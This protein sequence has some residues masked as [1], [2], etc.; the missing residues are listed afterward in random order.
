MNLNVRFLG[1]GKYLGN[2]GD[3]SQNSTGICTEK[4]LGHYG[5]YLNFWVH[6]VYFVS[7]ASFSIQLYWVSVSFECP[8]LHP[9]R[10]RRR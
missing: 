10:R 7:G 4:S 2:L 9:G 3:S 5:H 6:L 1:V 8:Q